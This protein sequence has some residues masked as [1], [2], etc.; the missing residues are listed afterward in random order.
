M[1]THAGRFLDGVEIL[2]QRRL[3]VVPRE[4]VGVEATDLPQVLDVDGM[5]VD[6]LVTLALVVLPA[7]NGRAGRD[8]VKL[9]PT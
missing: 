5:Q 2:V 9:G 6:H 8:T 1:Q 4:N 3:V 7:G